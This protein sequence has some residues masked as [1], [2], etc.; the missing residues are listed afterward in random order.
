MSQVD[1]KTLLVFDRI[2]WYHR[3]SQII[4]IK[5]NCLKLKLLTKDRYLL[6]SEFLTPTLADL[7]SVGV[8][9]TANLK[10]PE[11]FSVFWMVSTC[12]LI[13]KSIY[14]EEFYER[15]NYA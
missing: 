5:Y 3:N 1:V 13:Y 12:P 7:F 11:F 14:H 15:N 6:V 9:R 2:I 10:S 4:C 8:W